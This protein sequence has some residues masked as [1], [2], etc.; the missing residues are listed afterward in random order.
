MG[1]MLE[2]AR[3]GGKDS[4]PRRV[5][6]DTILGGYCSRALKGE[7]IIDMKRVLTRDVKKQYSGL[8][9]YSD[10]DERIELIVYYN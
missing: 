9:D 7:R 8:I 5:M 3:Q 2:Y 10:G 1:K 6:I 4:H